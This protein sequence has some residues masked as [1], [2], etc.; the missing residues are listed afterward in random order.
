MGKSKSSGHAKIKGEK[1]KKKS[2]I[3]PS[4]DSL[5]LSYRCITS[6]SGLFGCAVACILSCAAH[7]N[8]YS[9]EVSF[10][11]IDFIFPCAKLATK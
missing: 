2:I 6:N 7:L 3:R 4:W 9:H 5:V 11:S 10:Y 1:I 8:G